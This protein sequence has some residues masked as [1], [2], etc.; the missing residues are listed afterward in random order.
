MNSVLAHAYRETEASAV[1]VTYDTMRW[2]NNAVSI[3]TELMFAW[4]LHESTK[5][6]PF[7]A[8]AH[9]A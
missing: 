1:Y 9:L 8:A 5:Y 2:A 4:Q 7:Q 3:Q 6:N